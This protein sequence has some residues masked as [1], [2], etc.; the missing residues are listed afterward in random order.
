MT[1]CNYKGCRSIVL[2]ELVDADYKFTLIDVGSYG[3]NSDGEIFSKSTIG[4]MLENKTLIVHED[5]RMEY[6]SHTL[7]VILGDETFPLK[8]YLLH[9]YSRCHLG[10]N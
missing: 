5:V 10:E 7:Y 4:K 6:H 3:R 2:L 8:R 1:F 9:P